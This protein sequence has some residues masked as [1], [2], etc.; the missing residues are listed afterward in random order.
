MNAKKLKIISFK[1]E[2]EPS[3][4]NWTKFS[5]SVEAK[6]DLCRTKRYTCLCGTT[7]ESPDVIVT[8][9]DGAWLIGRKSIVGQIVPEYL[10]QEASS[11]IFYFFISYV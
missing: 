4:W 2:A 5:G 7:K 1:N 9:V 8:V 10:A 3:W 11:T 6:A